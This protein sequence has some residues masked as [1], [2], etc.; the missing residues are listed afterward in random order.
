M[1]QPNPLQDLV[2]E[3]GVLLLDGAMG[4]LLM[5][6]GLTSGDPPE[7][8]NVRYPERIEE[9]HRRYIDAGSRLIL[10]NS[11]G[12]SRF[13]LKLHRLDNRVTELNR[14][15]AGIAR[16]AADA[17]PHKV[18]VAGSIGP[19]GELLE[20]LGAMSFDEAKAAFA[21]Q[22][23]ALAEGGVDL[24]W[25]ET[26]SDLEEVR[27]AVEGAREAT[28]LPVAATMTFDT[29]RHTM[30]GVSPEQAVQA[31]GK[32]GLVAL[33]ANCGNGPDEIE[34]VIARMRAQNPDVLLIAKANAG[35]PHFTGDELVY[36]GTPALMGE[37]ARHVRDLG[38]NLV[39]GCCGNTPEH[40]AH[41]A[42]ALAQ[43]TG[44]GEAGFVRAGFKPAP[45]DTASASRQ[46]R[47]RRR[48]G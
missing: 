36:D 30:M 24:L 23:A 19:T 22:A 31:L 46:R 16:R 26:M 5:E 25:V 38:A 48:E 18:L 12:G 10:T 39:G 4:T 43:P 37:Y 45:T 17:A 29:N 20:P 2:A 1:T 21:E 41:M 28:D 42:E 27:A 8:W 7:D 44:S 47:H 35:I 33:G 6:M 14:A 9:V 15:A 34:E 40:I 3:Q 13:R 32:M 11:F